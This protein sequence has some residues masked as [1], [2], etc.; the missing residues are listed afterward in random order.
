MLIM[1]RKMTNDFPK[2]LPEYG[3]RGNPDFR[4]YY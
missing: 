4:T 1:K 3:V 2:Q